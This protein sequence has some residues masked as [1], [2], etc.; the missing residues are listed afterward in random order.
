MKMRERK[1]ARTTCKHRR[2]Q[3]GC[4]EKLWL[5]QK[6]CTPKKHTAARMSICFALSLSIVIALSFPSV[7][8]FSVLKLGTRAPGPLSHSWFSSIFCVLFVAEKHKRESTSERA[9]TRNDVH[10]SMEFVQRHLS[11]IVFECARCERAKRTQSLTTGSLAQNHRRPH[12][13]GTGSSKGRESVSILVRTEIHPVHTAHEHPVIIVVVAVVVR[14]SAASTLSWS[15]VLCIGRRSGGT[16]WQV[17]PNLPN[18][19]LGTSSM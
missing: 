17:F 13:Y 19:R 12:A 3:H 18:A 14:L 4:D 6:S 10:R 5:S 15:S 9:L 7:R 2:G 1:R 8:A 16:F 11:D